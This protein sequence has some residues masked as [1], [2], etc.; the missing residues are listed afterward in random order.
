V[1]LDVQVR[2]DL[3][4]FLKEDSER[5]SA[6]ILCA[7]AIHK[8]PHTALI[9]EAPVS[10]TLDATHIFDGLNE[11]PTHIAHMRLGSFVMNPIPW[12]TLPVEPEVSEPSLFQTALRWL[13]E[14]RQHRRELEK[15][16]RKIRGARPS[17]VR[18]LL[19]IG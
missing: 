2:D 17:Q 6:T 18:T 8:S 19:L 11:F 15:A 10:V 16:G 5:R 12:P 3:L 9:T 1:D 7:P 14:D 4:S 13:R